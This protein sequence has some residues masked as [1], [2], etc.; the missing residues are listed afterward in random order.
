MAIHEMVLLDD[1][2]RE[3]ITK[4]HPDSMYRQ[5]VEQLGFKG[6]FYDGL[7]KVSK[8]LTTLEEVYRVIV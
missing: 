4:K 5:Y 8:G 3:M 1:H 6:M 2:L 7:D